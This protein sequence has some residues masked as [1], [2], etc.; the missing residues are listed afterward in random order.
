MSVFGVIKTHLTRSKTLIAV[1]LFIL[2]SIGWTYSMIAVHTPKPS[3][4]TFSFGECRGDNLPCSGTINDSDIKEISESIASAIMNSRRF[5]KL[6]DVYRSVLKFEVGVRNQ[7][8]AYIKIPPNETTFHSFLSVSCGAET[9]TALEIKPIEDFFSLS[10]SSEPLVASVTSFV[11]TCKEVFFLNPDNAADLPP[12]PPNTTVSIDFGPKF[13]VEFKG[14][15]LNALII[16][17]FHSL[18]LLSLLP[19]LKNSW[20][21]FTNPTKYLAK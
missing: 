15:L 6:S 8:D 16:W 21:F 14:D 3:L 17:L 20:Q 11:K 10:D 7:S 5:G 1:A 9:L 4:L 2:I 12:V 13:K 19:V 18:I